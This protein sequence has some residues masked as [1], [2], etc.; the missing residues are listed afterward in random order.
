MAWL[1]LFAMAGYLIVTISIMEIVNS[2]DISRWYFANAKLDRVAT[3]I[4]QKHRIDGHFPD[5]IES[6]CN[7]KCREDP[8]NPRH[9]FS[10]KILDHNMAIIY[11]IGPDGEN[12]NG[13]P[14]LDKKSIKYSTSSLPWMFMPFRNYIMRLSGFDKKLKGDIVRVVQ[15]K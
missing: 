15:I 4:E 2:T 1:Q 14:A 12:N 3:I 10:Y 6:L 8:Y 9:E 11:S 7:S 13:E 5:S